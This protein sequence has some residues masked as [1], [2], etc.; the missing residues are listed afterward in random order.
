[1]SFGDALTGAE[2]DTSV[3]IELGIDGCN[4]GKEVIAK[5]ID[6]CEEVNTELRKL[7]TGTASVDL[8]KYGLSENQTSQDN[9]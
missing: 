8:S 1:M 4:S 3:V 2:E 7:K 9:L 5:L 6:G